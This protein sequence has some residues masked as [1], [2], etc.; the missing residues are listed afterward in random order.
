[1]AVE[2]KRR[3]LPPVKPR[4]CAWT[5]HSLLSVASVSVSSL[6]IGVGRQVLD[7]IGPVK[8]RKSDK[9]VV[10]GWQQAL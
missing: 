5:H 6:R 10:S 8:L 2:I 1:M 3:E 4:S 9:P 7:V